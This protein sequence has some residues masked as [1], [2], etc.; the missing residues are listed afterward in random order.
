MAISVGIIEDHSEFRQSLVYL[1]S[2]FSDYSVAWSYSS[3]EEAI[4]RNVNTDIVLLDINLPGLSGIEAIPLLKQKFA[5][6]RHG[7]VD[8]GAGQ[9]ETGGDVV[10]DRSY[11]SIET[12]VCREEN[13]N[14]HHSRR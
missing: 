3:A 4:E 9:G 1:I 13:Y 6:H 12:K 10:V 7:R 5:G 8:L 2:S 11:T 14:A